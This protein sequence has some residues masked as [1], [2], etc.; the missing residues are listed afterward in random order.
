M[1]TKHL[2]LMGISAALLLAGSISNVGLNMDKVYAAGEENTTNNCYYA[3][4]DYGSD[5]ISKYPTNWQ[6]KKDVSV[7]FN[8]DLDL[9]WTVSFAR[10]T[11]GH[12]L[13]LGNIN[14]IADNYE[15]GIAIS[16]AES[17]ITANE[18]PNSDYFKISEA[19]GY[20]GDT[21]KYVTAVIS[22]DFISEISDINFY[23]SGAEAG[24]VTILYQEEVDGDWTVVRQDNGEKSNFAGT[25]GNVDGSG[26]ANSWNQ[27]A[28]V[29]TILNDWNYNNIKD[30]SVR[31]AFTFES[32][33]PG[34]NNLNFRGIKINTLNSAKHYLNKLANE[35]GI[36]EKLTNN[37]A[38]YKTT[39]EMINYKISNENLQA[40]A[41]MP[42]IGNTNESTYYE[43]NSYL[44]EYVGLGEVDP[45]GLYLSG[46]FVNN[47][48]NMTIII[49]VVS[50]SVAV[51]ISLVLFFIIKNKK[52]KSHT[53]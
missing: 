16:P 11:S 9:T 13:A 39:L 8:N 5:L 15:N 46:S 21:T 37:T 49:T 19:L 7:K 32:Y 40:L 51:A 48:N 52:Q 34:A 38:S 4:V 42:I 12:Q 27:H 45:L 41:D 18:D 43:F 35:E 10:R 47:N 28:A 2:F 31:I 20:A 22:D 6:Y 26:V 53:K 30:K 23:F 1:K 29:M 25:N 33:S 3:V 50:F 44:K 36:C 17:T 24:Y 14:D